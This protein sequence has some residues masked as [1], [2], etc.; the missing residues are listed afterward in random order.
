LFVVVVE[1]YIDRKIVQQFYI[2]IILETFFV[3]T[4]K[5][6]REMSLNKSKFDQDGSK[7]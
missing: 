3:L 2:L 7:V 4:P 1:L 5:F 6:L